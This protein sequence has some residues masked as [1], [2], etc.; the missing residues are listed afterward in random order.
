MISWRPATVGDLSLIV[1]V[2][3]AHPFVPEPGG[4]DDDERSLT[5]RGFAQAEQLVTQLASPE[6][7][8]IVSSPHLRAVQ[9]VEP[10]ARSV[11]LPVHTDPDLREWESGIGPTSDYAR[12]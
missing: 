9:T 1:L 6:P 3:H 7:A 8:L 12:H 4:P 2:R 10:L 11:G 5:P